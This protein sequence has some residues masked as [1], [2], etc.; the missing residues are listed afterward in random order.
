MAFSCFNW[1]VYIWSLQTET[2]NKAT[3][4]DHRGL[5]SWHLHNPIVHIMKWKPCYQ[6]A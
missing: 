3:K 5:K 6:L 2:D 1:D 4:T